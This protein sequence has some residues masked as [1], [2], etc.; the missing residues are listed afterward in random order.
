MSRKARYGLVKNF[1][2][3][4]QIECLQ[5]IEAIVSRPTDNLRW[6]YQSKRSEL[7]K[8]KINTSLWMIDFIESNFSHT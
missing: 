2:P 5:A 7:L 3:S 6:E 1:K 4:Q 8:T